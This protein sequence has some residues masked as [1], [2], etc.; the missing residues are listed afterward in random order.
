M[1][2]LYLISLKKNFPQTKLRGCWFHFNQ[3][4]QRRIVKLGYFKLY[5]HNVE[6]RLRCKLIVSL[7]FVPLCKITEEIESL[8]FYFSSKIKLVDESQILL[9]WFDINFNK[10]KKYMNH[11][12]VFWSVRSRL[13][14][15]IPLTTNSLE[16]YNRHLNS[17]ANTQ[18]PSIYSLISEL[19]K[20]MELV[21]IE[22]IKINNTIS[23]PQTKIQ[24]KNIDIVL[25]YGTIIGINF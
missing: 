19:K 3:I 4:F 25:E 15:N 23:F 14:K 17:V 16:A 10:N 21:N 8:K 9:N 22:I 1:N 13:I 6:F 24:N 7:A 20:E 12:S 5:K 18:H 11:N 2:L